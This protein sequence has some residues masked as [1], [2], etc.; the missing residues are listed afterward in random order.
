MNRGMD[1]DHSSINSY[2]DSQNCFLNE[3]IME[4]QSHGW[5]SMDELCEYYMLRHE[6]AMKMIKL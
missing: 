4:K 1:I 6:L 2:A 3:A 5:E